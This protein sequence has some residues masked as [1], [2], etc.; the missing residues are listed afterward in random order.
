[1]KNKKGFLLAEFSLK[2]II[3]VLS[4]ALLIYL[5]VAIYS[6]FSGDKEQDEAEASLERVIQN[7]A[8]IKNDPQ[9]TELSIII[10]QPKSWVFVYYLN[11]VPNDCVGTKCLCICEK[12]SLDSCNQ[13]VCKI[14]GDDINL[15]TGIKI[16]V[17]TILIKEETDKI[18]ISE[19]KP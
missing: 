10:T 12:D 3:A 8:A 19:V 2:T 5:L 9:N 6:I 18:V 4:I 1:M 7:I 14:T 15:Q 16:D 11:G 13:G 17:T